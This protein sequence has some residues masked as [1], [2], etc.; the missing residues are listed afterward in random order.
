MPGWHLISI[1]LGIDAA[2]QQ[3]LRAGFLGGPQRMR[4]APSMRKS[5]FGGDMHG[6]MF[7]K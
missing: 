5:G 3:A 7:H 1:S 4:G 2:G 6:L